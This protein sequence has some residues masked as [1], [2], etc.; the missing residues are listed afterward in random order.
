MAG[1]RHNSNREMDQL[2][3]DLNNL[4]VEERK[5]HC[6]VAGCTRACVYVGDTDWC[7]CYEWVMYN[8]FSKKWEQTAEPCVRCYILSQASDDEDEQAYYKQFPALQC[9][10][11]R[12]YCPGCATKFAPEAYKGDSLA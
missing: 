5:C 3:S 2:A 9:L 10:I 1:K 6:V 7:F 12:Y 11:A 4:A 8:V